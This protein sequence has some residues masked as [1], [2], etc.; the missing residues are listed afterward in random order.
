M[1]GI[2]DYGVGN[3]RAFANI[4]DHAGCA[5]KI[6]NSVKDLIG[7]KKILLPGV[8]AFDYAMSMLRRSGLCDM[9]DN[10]VLNEKMPVLGVCVGMQIMASSS[11]E[12]ECQ[13]LGWIPG[14][15]KKINN[16][17]GL[18]LPHMGWNSI[19]IQKKSPIFH[20]IGAENGF[21]FLHSYYFECDGDREV[22]ATTVYSGSF[23]SVVGGD[24]I[25]GIQCHPEKSH[26]D[27]IQLL[28]NFGDLPC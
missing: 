3:I 9:L 22:L 21:Y 28:K 2:I 10:L 27:G 12:G 14:K 20:K 26:G 17:N 6:V 5:Y 15:V 23:S 16:S 24:H 1:I 25:F 7:V 13:G 11:E 4:Y 18:P 8:G 19:D